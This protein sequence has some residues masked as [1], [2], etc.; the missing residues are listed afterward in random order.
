MGVYDGYLKIRTKLDNK[1][2][3]KDVAELENK[4]KK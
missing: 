4:I 3:D 2:I 1:G